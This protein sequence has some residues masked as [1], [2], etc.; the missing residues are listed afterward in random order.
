MRNHEAQQIERSVL[1]FGEIIVLMKSDVA[2]FC[3]HLDFSQDSSKPLRLSLK[4]KAR[5]S[6]NVP[7]FR[8]KSFDCFN[9]TTRTNRVKS[10][11]AD[12]L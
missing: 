7:C 5:E 2:N 3:Q 12:L 10:P 9:Q 11:R 8:R 1:N 6:A 4:T